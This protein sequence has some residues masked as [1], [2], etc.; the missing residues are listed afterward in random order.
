MLSDE[1]EG[2]DWLRSAL[3]TPDDIKTLDRLCAESG[4]PVAKLMD[5]AGHAVANA[6]AARHGAG[7]AVDVLVGPGNNGGD[8]SVAAEVLRR[9]GFDVVLI[10]ASDGKGA[11]IARDALAAYKGPRAAADPG[12]L[13]RGAVVIDALFGVGLARPPEGSVAE[14]VEAA[15][16]RASAIYAVDIASGVNGATGAVDGAAIRADWTVALHAMKPGHVLSPGA[17]Q[18]GRVVVEDIGI[19]PRIA[20]KVT[21]VAHLNH[22]APE[23]LAECPL[24]SEAGHKYDRGS[25]YVVSGPTD[26]TG[27][28]RLAA[29]AALRCG[30]GLVTV[31]SP[32]SALMVNAMHLTAVMVKAVDGADV[33]AERVAAASRAPTVLLGPGL[34]P[35]GRTRDMVLAALASAAKVVLD[36]GAL[37]AFADDPETLKAALR[38]K[39][40]ASTPAI[41]TPHGGEFARIFASDGDKLS[42]GRAAAAELGAVV[43]EKGA[44]TVIDGRIVDVS[45][46]PWLATAGTGDVLAGLITGLYAQGFAAE[47]AACLG[48][49][50]QGAMAKRLGPGMISE[51]LLRVIAPVRA[52]LEEQLTAARPRPYIW[53]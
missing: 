2:G 33:L 34:P 48:V 43:V 53:R 6:V 44:D 37:T 30:A 12:S 32:P 51:D 8:G 10:D 36:A 1:K 39:G 31:L 47:D 49:R 45:G 19:P 41:L 50:M 9:R 20:R 25:V 16:A 35:D 23:R 46:P 52:A 13:R 3:L 4:M 24:L 38:G 5:N 17:R 42:R 29:T 27:A 21:P 26:A 15:N 18:A 22:P 14:L 40:E 28:A 11:D 7:S